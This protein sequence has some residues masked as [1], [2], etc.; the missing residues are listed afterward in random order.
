MCASR[1]FFIFTNLLL[2]VPIQKRKIIFNK[3][4]LRRLKFPKSQIVQEIIGRLD[5]SLHRNIKVI[6]KRAAGWD[7]SDVWTTP[8]IWVPRS[9]L[10]QIVLTPKYLMTTTLAAVHLIVLQDAIHDF[11]EFDHLSFSSFVGCLH[12]GTLVGQ[13]S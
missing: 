5:L 9:L 11:F 7:N 6:G 8:D 1:E 3:T 13:T 10:E 2:R 12:G 4:L